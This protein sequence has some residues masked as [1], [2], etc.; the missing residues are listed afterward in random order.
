MKQRILIYITAIGL[1]NLFSCEKDED[2][3]V[4]NTTLTS[5]AILN[6]TEG[7]TIVLEEEDKDNTIEFVW[8]TAQYG[9]PASVFYS[10]QL[11]EQGNDFKSII[12]VVRV[13]QIGW[14][15]VTIV[16]FFFGYYGVKACISEYKK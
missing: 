16:I 11:D 3:A 2:R 14:I 13:F 15:I 12:E 7:Q 10:V 5:P 8:S 4:L 9:F 6:Y 1:I